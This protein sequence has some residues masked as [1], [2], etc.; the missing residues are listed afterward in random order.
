MCK[1]L[2]KMSPIVERLVALTEKGNMYLINVEVRY[3]Y[4]ERKFCTTTND[5]ERT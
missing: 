1:M 2:R 3:E 4:N 5:L